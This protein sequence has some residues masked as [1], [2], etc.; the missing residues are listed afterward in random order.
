MRLAHLRLWTRTVLCLMGMALLGSCSKYSRLLKSTDVDARYHGSMQYFKKK[1]YYHA[2]MVLEETL[3]LLK[4]STRADTAQLYYA[5]CQFYEKQYN[6]AAF[7]FKTFYETF[8][9]TTFAEEAAYMEGLS[10]YEDSPRFDLDQESTKEAIRVVQTFLTQ[11]PETERKEDCNF[12][13]DNLRA[14]LERKAYEQA[15]LYYRKNNYQA[16]I[17]AFETFRKEFPESSRNEE[18][19]ALKVEAAYKLAESSVPSKQPER[20]GQ[21]LSTYET[22]ID[23]YPD[24]KRAG[25]AEGFYA[26]AQTWL[27]VHNAAKTPANAT[28]SL[29]TP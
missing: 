8:P 29:T 28:S 6:L 19:Q 12:I 21:V 9:R 13:I 15:F 1:D 23:R 11:Y 14:K 16:S 25:K 26:S 17:I 10:Y 24:S 4:G 5:Y 20:Y 7:Y 22:F 18:V 27:Q 3:P 2:G